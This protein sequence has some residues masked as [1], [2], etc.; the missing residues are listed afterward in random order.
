MTPFRLATLAAL[1]LATLPLV[2]AAVGLRLNLTASLPIGVYREIPGPVAPGD[3]ALA[4]PPASAATTQAQRRGYYASGLRCP[5]RIAPVVKTVA[6]VAGDHVVA[7]LSGLLV[8]GR[9]IP[10]TSPL[11]R[12]SAGRP[13]LPAHVAGTLPPGRV[14]LA[15]TYSPHSFDSRYHGPWPASSI[16]GRV[17]PVWTTDDPRRHCRA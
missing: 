2:P 12:D 13:L 4:C 17:L 8:N 7:D 5:G 10:C 16:R 3:L 11:T 9:R 6:A 15:S 1:G 14:W